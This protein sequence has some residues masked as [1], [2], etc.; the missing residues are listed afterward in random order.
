M[1]NLIEGIDNVENEISDTYLLR[2][3]ENSGSSLVESLEKNV[4]ILRLEAYQAK[5][6]DSQLEAKLRYFNELSNNLTSKLYSLIA[7]SDLGIG[8]REEIK[9][10]VEQITLSW[11]HA[12]KEFQ[13]MEFQVV[14]E[15]A[16]IRVASRTATGIPLTNVLKRIKK[17]AASVKVSLQIG[18]VIYDQ[19]YVSRGYK[20]HEEI[21]QILDSLEHCDDKVQQFLVI[22]KTTPYLVELS[23]TVDG[24]VTNTELLLPTR[25]SHE[26]PEDLRAFNFVI[27]LLTGELLGE[28][29][30]NP[31][32]I[33]IE[34]APKKPVFITLNNKRKMNIPKISGNKLF[35]SSTFPPISFK[36]V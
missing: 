21:V 14:K 20:I 13:L 6:I 1:N 25:K 7:L 12:N 28:E 35:R 22:C 29:T 15:Y 34:N 5:N 18:S 4:E 30:T 26:K 11:V 23:S 19:D 9:D 27:K 33:L 17:E 8:N 32:Q 31:K 10:F 16:A 3:I 36:T 24:F 2:N